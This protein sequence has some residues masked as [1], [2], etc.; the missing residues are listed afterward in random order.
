MG[1]STAT[2]V[3]Q[4]SLAAIAA[5]SAAISR[6]IAGASVSGTFTEKTA[7]VV[8]TGDGGVQ[9]LTVTGAQNPTLFAAMLEATSSSATQTSIANGLSS[10]EETVG[11]TNSDTSPAA[12]L[13]DFI[14]SMQSYEA[15]PSNS[16]LAA[17]AVTAA[18]NLTTTLNEATQ[19]VQ[20]VRETADQDM[21]ASVTTINGLLT[22][23][24]SVNTQIVTGTATGADISDLEDTR[25]T[26]LTQLS[27]Q[28]GISTTTGPDNNMSLYT[29]SGVT[30]FQGGT[31]STVTFQP[32]SAYSPGT[33]GNAV[34]ID[35][36]P[37]TGS[38]ATM[39]IQSGAL[40]GFAS[41]RDDT[42]VTYQSQLDQIAHG[43]I[44]ATSEAV[45]SGTTTTQVPGLFTFTGASGTPP[46]MPSSATGLA[47]TIEVNPAVDPSQ[48][49]NPELVGNGINTN[50]N[51]AGDASFTT[52]IQNLITNL[53]ADQTFSASAGLGTTSSLS[54]FASSSVSWLEATRQSNSNEGSFQSTLLTSTTSAFTGATGVSLDNEMSKMLDLE[55][56]YSSSAQL[57]TTINSMFTTLVSAVTAINGASA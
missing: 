41:L 1:L 27:Q 17:A 46:A 50:F 4:S 43:L 34:V 16:S 18:G 21:A 13:S 32:T 7:N 3:A 30:L 42:A 57:M 40:A 24:Q 48:G 31:P 19:T 51:T 33:T 2:S 49:G 23:F 20:G 53:Q 35:G 44:S 9:A 54:N 36:V 14:D 5:E 38:G 22:Q 25:D 37:V 39:P 26:I 28:I 15:S 52:Q 12:Q 56:S 10:L 8:T 6:N 55:N 47:G 11:S 29:D 45:P